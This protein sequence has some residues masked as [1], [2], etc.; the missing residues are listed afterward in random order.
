MAEIVWTERALNSLVEIARFIAQDSP[1]F[2]RAFVARIVEAVD[3][4]ALFPR[5]G[6]QVPEFADETLREVIFQ[7]Y[8]IVYRIDGDRVG[9][10]IVRHAAMNLPAD[11]GQ[12]PWSLP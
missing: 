3:R 5:L 10:V 8:R 1:E 7:N 6:R 11:V 9:V 4:I 12:P 2:A